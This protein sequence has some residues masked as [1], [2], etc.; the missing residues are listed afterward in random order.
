MPCYNRAFCIEK[1]INSVLSQTEQNFELII[2]DDGSE[3]GTE[4]LLKQKYRQ[5][6]AEG[7]I[8]FYALREHG[9]VCKARNKGLSLSK[10][11]WIGYVDS[12]NEIV[13]D[14]LETFTKAI[15]ENKAKIFY[16]GIK[17]NY[18]GNVLSEPFNYKK[19]QQG[20]YIDMGALV[21]ARSVYEDLGGFDENLTRVVDWDL[22]LKYTKKYRPVYLDK[23]V[24]R[25]EDSKSFPR[26]SNT[27]SITMNEWLI[28][29]KYLPN[30]EIKKQRILGFIRFS[31]P[32]GFAKGKNP[33]EPSYFEYRLKIFK[34]ITLVSLKA[35]TDKNFN[36][37][38]LHSKKMPA[39]YKVQ[40]DVWERKYP[41]LH[42]VY[43]D[44]KESLAKV[45]KDCATAYL[46]FSKKTV[47]TFRLD[48]DDA[49]PEN[50]ID[51]LCRYTVKKY[52]GTAISLPNII[53]LQRCE[54]ERYLV[55]H[56][57]YLSN[58]I[59]LAYVSA[60]D[61]FVNVIDLGHHG[62]ICENVPLLCLPGQGGI[63]T[64]NGENVANHFT[65]PEKVE[66]ISEAQLKERLSVNFPDFDWHCLKVF[67][68][69]IKTR[70][71]Q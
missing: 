7:K 24:V 43:L 65:K 5:E 1:A 18:S 68:S 37:V 45:I 63:Q 2:V 13:P 26:I 20:N 17:H 32:C 39:K 71:N 8:V 12:D 38:L 56:N 42:N 21:H 49:L 67:A 30:P 6:L 41:F 55:Y 4:D 59:G 3:D 36:V 25:Y 54:E 27:E 23:I 53:L 46:D 19:L 70:G 69:P 64:I 35:Q 40:F 15:R 28:C 16:A 29:Q 44:E 60:A 50:F 58:A 52:S 57:C 34:K 9:G 10:N 51:I 48:N 14:F 66:N 33:F 11:L 47:C 62:L 31:C 61:N 22:A